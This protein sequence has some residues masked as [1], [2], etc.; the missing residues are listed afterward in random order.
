MITDRGEPLIVYKTFQFLRAKEK[1]KF[2]DKDDV[3][4]FESHHIVEK[5]KQ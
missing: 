4:T 2:I 3:N 5:K 1:M